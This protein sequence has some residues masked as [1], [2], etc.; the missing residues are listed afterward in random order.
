[1]GLGSGRHLQSMRSTDDSAE[2]ARSTILPPRSTGVWHT[3]GAS[4][5][6]SG[7]RTVKMVGLNWSGFETV[8]GVPGGL[9]ERDYKEVLEN[10]QNSG[11]NVVR[12]PLS[13]EMVES[14]RVPTDIGYLGQKGPINQDL[15]DLTSMEI[16][17]KV[18]SYSQAIGLKLILDNHRSDAGGGPQENG[19]WFTPE[20]P[21]S[22]WL[23]D[24]VGLARR[25]ANTP[26][27]IGFDLRNE[28][29]GANGSG[30]CWDCGGPRDWHLAAQRAGNAIQRENGGLLIIVEGTDEYRGDRYWWGSNLEGVRKSPVELALPNHLVYSAHE[31]GPMEYPQPWFTPAL[32]ARALEQLWVKHWAFI[33]DLQIAPVYLGEFGT[34]ND[35]ASIESTQSDLRGNGSVPSSPFCRIDR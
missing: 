5:L 24:W 1:M 20:Y 30:A 16:L 8:N 35:A 7:G 34:T 29:H 22:S 17:D 9:K 15:K 28:P 33:S 27:V 3:Q 2:Q 4:L 11:F 31:Y 23:K 32:S 26:S 25:Y 14:P 10:I 13:N 19:L 12:L 6:D 21:E 18:V